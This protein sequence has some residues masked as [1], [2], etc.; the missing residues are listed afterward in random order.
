M[1]AF[2]SRGLY[3]DPK[4]VVMV[5]LGLTLPELVQWWVYEPHPA[6][7]SRPE[8]VGEPAPTAPHQLPTVTMQGG[9]SLPPAWIVAGAASALIVGVG[10]GGAWI[11][12]RSGRDDEDGATT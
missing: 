9:S 12:S 7:S 5:I 2:F 6:L 4:V 11:L 3:K 10:V 8:V 1:I